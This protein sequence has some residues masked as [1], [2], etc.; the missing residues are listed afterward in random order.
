MITTIDNNQRIFLVTGDMSKG[1]PGILCNIQDL[2]KVYNSFDDK[3]SI[4][5]Q[6][7]WNHR[8]VSCSTKSIV[9]ML[10]SLN[11]NHKFL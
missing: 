8:F 5:I 9:D 2:E 4:R 6:H 1:T 3:N 11:L 10:K 7:K